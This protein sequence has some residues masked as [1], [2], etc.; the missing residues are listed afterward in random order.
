MEDPEAFL[1]DHRGRRIVLDEI[2]RLGNPSQL[3]KIAADHFPST[4]VIATGSSV[5]GA[6][7]K[8]RDT[9]AGR[10][11]E[12]WLTPMM[13][14]DLKEFKQTNL[15]HR[16]FRGG[17]PP[18]FLSPD[19][20][21]RDIQEWMDAYWAK[22]IQGLFRLG[23]RSSFEKFLE[24]LI[25]QS[26][27]MFEATRFTRPCEVSR[28]TILNYLRALEATLIVH[29]VR[30]FS[31]H[32]ATEIVAAPK[33]YAFDTGFL[34]YYRGWHDLRNEDLGVLWEH[35]VL[36]EIHASMQVRTIQ[37][38]R[39][40]RG[41]EVDFVYRRRGQQPIAIE[42]KWSAKDFN[43]T[44]LLAFWKQYPKATMYVVAQD[45]DRP[46]SKQVSGMAVS[47]L[48]LTGLISSLSH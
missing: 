1:Q 26:G 21:E 29:I 22:D 14:S 33:V 42:C 20:P 5:L 7:M 28:P 44:N 32:H 9:L 39:D 35:F 27:G 17:L 46:Y 38:W 4:R 43:T 34:C 2:L 18:F 13:S 23:R 47:F 10:K 12:I 19:F 11:A 15:Q 25:A 16:L 37:Y 48:S 40:K 45:V 24:L 3:L 31:A 6:S 41:H 8:F 30:P 36:N